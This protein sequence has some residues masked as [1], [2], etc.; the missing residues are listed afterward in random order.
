MRYNVDTMNVGIRELKQHLS[1][2][3]ARARE[4]ETIVITDRGV[5][6]AKL[7]KVQTDEPPEALKHLIESGKLMYKGSFRYV[8]KAIRM[9]PG[10]K[11]AVDYVREQ[12][13]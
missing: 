6:V 4:G 7:E 2:Y 13:R 9:L 3:V 12:R 8:P 1:R 5:P 11:T 10:E